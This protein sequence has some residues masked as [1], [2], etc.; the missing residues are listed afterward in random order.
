MTTKPITVLHRY[1]TMDKSTWG[2]GP[3]MNEPDKVQFVDETTGMACLIVRNQYCGFWCGYV[4]IDASH[5]YHQTDYRNIDSD[6]NAHGGLTFSNFCRDEDAQEQSICHIP[7][8]GEPANLWWLGFDCGHAGDFNPAYDSKMKR[9]M[10]F[11]NFT[12]RDM[13][14]VIKE[15]IDLAR[16]LAT[17]Q[18]VPS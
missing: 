6:I 11:G 9:I 5:P 1:T 8:P 16:Q 15:C 14:Y 12:Y 10:H 7:Q 13:D 4:G 18:N 2:D 17:V 3:W